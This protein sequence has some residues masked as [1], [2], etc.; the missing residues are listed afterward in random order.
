MD[1]TAFINSLAEDLKT[2]L[3]SQFKDNFKIEEV[4]RIDVRVRSEEPVLHVSYELK[5]QRTDL[6]IAYENPVERRKRFS[7]GGFEGEIKPE[8]STITG[9]HTFRG[10]KIQGKVV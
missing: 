3:Y 8:W 1:R 2:T 10:K 7:F 4:N 6:S 9:K 5:M